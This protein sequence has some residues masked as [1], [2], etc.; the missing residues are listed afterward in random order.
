MLREIQLD[1]FLFSSGHFEQIEREV[2]VTSSVEKSSNTFKA[3]IL[4][5]FGVPS[6]ANSSRLQPVHSPRGHHRPPSGAIAPDA[7]ARQFA[8][9]QDSIPKVQN[10]QNLQLLSIDKNIPQIFRL[11]FQNKYACA[12][13]N[14]LVLHQS[15]QFI[16][17]SILIK[18]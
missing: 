18:F 13:I 14:I 4:P 10:T 12:L 16:I 1:L 5:E 17:F 2:I 8:W 6:G 7:P 3:R 11:S 9:T 15:M